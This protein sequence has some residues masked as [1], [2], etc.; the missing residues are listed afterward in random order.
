VLIANSLVN[1]WENSGAC[2]YQARYRITL[3]DALCGRNQSGDR[4]Q[5]EV[6]YRQSLEMFTEMGAP[7]YI[8]VLEERLGETNKPG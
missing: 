4:E 3:G 6:V 8:K 7:G 1:R 2:W 5:A